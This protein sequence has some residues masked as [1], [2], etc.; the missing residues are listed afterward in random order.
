MDLMYVPS[1]LIM[2]ETQSCLFVGLWS[3]K[4]TL[5]ERIPFSQYTT[6]C[7]SQWSFDGGLFK[8]DK[9]TK[10]HAFSLSECSFLF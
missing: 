1:M 8:C 6:F 5:N 3:R 10:A 9:C 2:I 7:T 4:F